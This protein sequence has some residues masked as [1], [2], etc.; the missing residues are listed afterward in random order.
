MLYA[1]IAILFLVVLLFYVKLFLILNSNRN[2]DDILKQIEDIENIKDFGSFSEPTLETIIVNKNENLEKKAEEKIEEGKNAIK[3]FNGEQ[4][5]I[6][7]Y[8]FPPSTFQSNVILNLYKDVVVVKLWIKEPFH[9]TF[10]SILNFVDKNSFYIRVP[11]T[12]KIVV[13][14]RTPQNKTV[15]TEVFEVF[16]AKEVVTKMIADIVKNID[17]KSFDESLGFIILTF[18]AFT[19]SKIDNIDAY[20]KADNKSEVLEFVVKRFCKNYNQQYFII[21]YN[22]INDILESSYSKIIKDCKRYENTIFKKYDENEDVLKLEDMSK[23]AKKQLLN[24]ICYP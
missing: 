14:L 18:F 9:T 19:I 23:T 3:K 6:K 21:F 4:E 8:I 24:P 13:N 1:I 11:L 22:D 15:K 2:N 12:R 20:I 7:Y 5:W 16:D 10:V 17:I